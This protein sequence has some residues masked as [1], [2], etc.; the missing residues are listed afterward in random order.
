M[1]SFEDIKFDKMPPLSPL[2]YSIWYRF[3]TPG[4][5]DI[6]KSRPRKLRFSNADMDVD[7]FLNG[8][9]EANPDL[10]I[11]SRALYVH[12]NAD[13][14]EPMQADEAILGYGQTL[15]DAVLVV[16]PSIAESVTG[17]F[18]IV[19]HAI[20]G[21]F[22]SCNE[23]F[24]NQLHNA[25]L[26]GDWLEFKD[27][28]PGT[29][30]VENLYV[31]QSFKTIHDSIQHITSRFS[32]SQIT[33]TGTPGVGKTLFMF[34]YLWDLVKRRKRV[35]FIHH[36]RIL[37][38]DGKGF[39]VWTGRHLPGNALTDPIDPNLPFWRNNLFCLLDCKHKDQTVFADLPYDSCHFMLSTSPNKDL[40]NDFKKG[41]PLDWKFYMPP[42]KQSELKIIAPQ[43]NHVN[44]WIDDFL[45]LGGVPRSLVECALIGESGFATEKVK[46]YLKSVS[47][48]VI[49]NIVDDQSPIAVNIQG[50][51]HTIVHL[52]SEPPYNKCVARFASGRS[53]SDTRTKSRNIGIS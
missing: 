11:P 27:I 18:V 35:L 29:A 40:L 38:F 53:S 20:V 12:E 25:N 47:L 15:A 48:D 9:C 8:V 44:E 33:L 51:V 22:V 2:T 28:V 5:N 52:H 46:N 24:Y 16:V 14:S 7:D 6:G 17:N 42:W 10:R 3:V 26:V 31:R 50:S 19:D 39:Y 21:A 13:A 23:S 43:F 4:M 49:L 32:T 34:Y 1:E 37:Y 41:K 36:P 30:N 45:V